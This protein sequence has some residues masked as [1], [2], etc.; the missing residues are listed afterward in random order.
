MLLLRDWRERTEEVPSLHYITAIVHMHLKSLKGCLD[1]RLHLRNMSRVSQ[2]DKFETEAPTSGIDMEVD[3]F[4]DT[5][6]QSS[7]PSAA[8]RLL[9]S[10]C[11]GR[12]ASGS[13]PTTL[14]D[15]GDG[16][17][18]APV[19]EDMA[20]A[21]AK[22]GYPQIEDGEKPSN[23]LPRCIACITKRLKKMAELLPTMPK[24]AEAGTSEA[25]ADKVAL[26]QKTWPYTYTCK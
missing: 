4:G 5:L 18:V 22:L 13:R 10:V 16:V 3:M 24:P 26:A 6:S 15:A 2:E 19:S 17:T 14:Q 12:H 25:P 11:H 7:S 20:K 8:I 1:C 23:L 9:R 21:L